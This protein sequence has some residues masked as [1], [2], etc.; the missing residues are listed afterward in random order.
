MCQICRFSCTE[1]QLPRCTDEQMNK[2]IATANT[3]ISVGRYIGANGEG[4]RNITEAHS[5][6]AMEC[7]RNSVVSPVFVPRCTVKCQAMCITKLAL[8]R[9]GYWT[10][11]VRFYQSFK[12]TRSALP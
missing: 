5:F 8:T 12:A 6:T 10:S 7:V 3:S 11:W 9:V 1:A 4:A 2:T